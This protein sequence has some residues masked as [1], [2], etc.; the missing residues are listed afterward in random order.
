MFKTFARDLPAEGWMGTNLMKIA[1]GMAAGVFAV[2]IAGHHRGRSSERHR[3]CLKWMQVGFC[4]LEGFG[5]DYVSLVQPVTI[6]Q[7]ENKLLK[8]HIHTKCGTS[9]ARTSSKRK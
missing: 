5:C 7:R 2:I 9:D 1:I 6:V 3:F 8:A 4:W